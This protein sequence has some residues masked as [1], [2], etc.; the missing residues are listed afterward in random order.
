MIRF[1][2][3]THIC[4][5]YWL[6]MGKLCP[7]RSSLLSFPTIVSMIPMLHA[8]IMSD[9]WNSIDNCYLFK[10]KVQELI[11]HKLSWF[12]PITIKA[13]IE[14]EF[15]YK[16]PPIHVQ[17]PLYV[18]MPDVQY[19]YQ[20]YHPGMPLAYHGASSS[21]VVAPQYAYLGVPYIPVGVQY[22]QTSNQMGNPG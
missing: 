21:T 6:M 18:V 17:V 11:H 22:D 9:I 14:K 15:E 8:N 20:G 12:T 19:H 4:C 2:C 5:L 13:P 7:N 16:G 10:A 3:L 1:Q